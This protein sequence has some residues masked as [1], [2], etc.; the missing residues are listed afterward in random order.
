MF[1]RVSYIYVHYLIDQHILLHLQLRQ[2]YVSLPSSDIVINSHSSVILTISSK[3]SRGTV[4]HEKF[5]TK[6]SK[7]ILNHYVFT[8]IALSTTR[9]F[10]YLKNNEFIL[11]PRTFTPRPPPRFFSGEILYPDTVPGIKF[12]KW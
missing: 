5:S 10:L 1:S 8:F 12:I 4:Y 3:Y 6:G 7:G 2:F 11:T 9:Y